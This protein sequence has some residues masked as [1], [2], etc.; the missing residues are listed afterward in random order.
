MTAGGLY[1]ADL[2]AILDGVSSPQNRI[3]EIN[4]LVLRSSPEIVAGKEA[5]LQPQLWIDSGN[6]EPSVVRAARKRPSASLEAASVVPRRVIG[7]ESITDTEVFAEQFRE[8]KS[9]G[10]PLTISL[11]ICSGRVVSPCRAIA[12]ASPMENLGWFVELGI[13]EFIILDLTAVGSQ[14]GPVTVDLCERV[15]REF[16]RLQA[17]RLISGGGVRNESDVCRLI[18]AGCNGVLVA[19]W[20]QGLWNEMD[21]AG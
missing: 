1:V 9:A 5:C 19:S 6:I 4:R 15:S 12:T 10:L 17:F 16:Q 8:M 21:F 20:L 11:D 14:A 7:T 13:R 18:D 2:D 3:E